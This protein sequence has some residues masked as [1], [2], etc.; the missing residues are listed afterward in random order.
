MHI[1]I[2]C[3]NSLNLITKFKNVPFLFEFRKLNQEKGDVV[4][5]ESSLYSD[6]SINFLYY[7]GIL[8]Q[9]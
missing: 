4:I 8:F 3:N 2:V 7:S 9:M 5:F 6:F 1:R